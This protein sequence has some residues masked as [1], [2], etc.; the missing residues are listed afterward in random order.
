MSFWSSLLLCLL[1]SS[2]LALL[3]AGLCNLQPISATIAGAV[4][5]VVFMRC[6][7]LFT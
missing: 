1:M 2:V 5:F 3:V 4:F 6:P 7:Q